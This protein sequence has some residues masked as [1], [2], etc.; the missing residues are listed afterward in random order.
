MPFLAK[1]SSYPSGPPI[2]ML[3]RLFRT[4]SLRASWTGP[5]CD[6]SQDAF[7]R[8]VLFKRNV[9]RSRLM[10]YW[11]GRLLLLGQLSGSRDFLNGLATWKLK[12]N[13]E[14]VTSWHET[15]CSSGT[16]NN[17]VKISSDGDPSVQRQLVCFLQN[18]RCP[19]LPHFGRQVDREDGC[20]PRR[21]FLIG[22]RHQGVTFG[23]G[24]WL[25]LRVLDL[26]LLVQIIQISSSIL[27]TINSWTTETTI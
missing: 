18:S 17:F 7:L 3:E 19:F 16:V 6:S 10:K 25:F 11:Q 8:L 21:M 20:I 13:S 27:I 5:R 24:L 22:N 26:L 4:F 1:F 2:S 23:F 9:N 15:V 12:S 14:A